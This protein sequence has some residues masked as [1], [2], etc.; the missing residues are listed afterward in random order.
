ML[1]V[2]WRMNIITEVG[3]MGVI[4]ESILIG[5]TAMNMNI[6]DTRIITDTIGTV[7]NSSFPGSKSFECLA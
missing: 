4:M 1:G 3:I 5:T 7:N 6:I 2:S